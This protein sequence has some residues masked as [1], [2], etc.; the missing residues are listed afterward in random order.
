MINI[1]FFRGDGPR[2]FNPYTI[3]QVLYELL[4]GGQKGKCRCDEF[5]V[6]PW[7]NL[8]GISL[9]YRVEKKWTGQLPHHTRVSLSVFL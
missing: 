6:N 3:L 2:Q 5:P 7:G 4:F 1:L 8:K 9:F